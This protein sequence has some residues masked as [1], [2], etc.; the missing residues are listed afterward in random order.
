MKIILSLFLLIFLINNCVDSQDKI[1]EL[2]KNEI[3]P[4]NRNDET[5][6]EFQ[7]KIEKIPGYNKKKIGYYSVFLS[8][9]E[10]KAGEE[11]GQE[12]V[13]Q[14][15]I[16]YRDSLDNDLDHSLNFKDLKNYFNKQ[17]T[18]YT[19]SDITNFIYLMASDH[20][21][22]DYSS[23]LSA[24]IKF[25]KDF[26]NLHPMWKYS[27]NG[28]AINRTEEMNRIADEAL[29]RYSRLRREYDQAMKDI[30]QE[31][32]RNLD[33]FRAQYEQITGKKLEK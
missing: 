11:I 3:N 33:N 30:D 32:K 1:K 16:Y 29:A 12:Y 8:N 5:M 9:D 31:I 28:I 19:D 2:Y 15:K 22:I 6:A 4:I 13:T 17:G 20:T 25:H 7:K 21:N 26:E 14:Y 24:C 18:D 27:L 23:F 10:I